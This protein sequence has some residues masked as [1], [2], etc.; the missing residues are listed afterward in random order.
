M[1]NAASL[2]LSPPQ[3]LS[4]ADINTFERDGLLTG[5]NLFDPEQAPIMRDALIREVLTVPSTADCHRGWAEA[6]MET[7]RYLDRRL[8][9]ELCTLE[10]ILN[11]I[12]QLLGNDL[13]LFRTQFFHKPG[14]GL[15][16]PWHQ[17]SFFWGA[18]D[19][20]VTLWLAIDEANIN[21]GPMQV[22]PGSHHQAYEHRPV[23]KDANYR[24]GF[25]QVAQPAASDRVEI[26]TMAAGQFML[27]ENLL[28]G[29]LPN[30]TSSSRLGFT[31]RYARPDLKGIQE[32]FYQDHQCLLVSG[33]S[34]NSQLRFGQ[35]PTTGQ[36]LDC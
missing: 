8:V 29:S 33:E 15:E 24:A 12:R 27:F 18:S 2:R 26:C 4:A 11:P 7:D 30:H 3:T 28:H 25:N 6:A 17:E 36:G 21:N 32:S 10:Q 5:F 23:A 14:F 20:W 13:V 35:P 16:I 31:A 9:Y 34:G 1:N 22:V 19:N